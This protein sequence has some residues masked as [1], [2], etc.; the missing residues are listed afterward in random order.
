MCALT[1]VV[2]RNK[3]P[4]AIN[5]ILSGASAP[6]DMNTEEYD[7]SL[8]VQKDGECCLIIVLVSV[9]ICIVTIE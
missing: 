4:M 3:V 8:L 6:V 7:F 5:Q 1:Q 2:R 9:L